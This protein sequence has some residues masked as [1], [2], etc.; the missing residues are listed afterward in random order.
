MS[1]AGSARTCHSER[2]E[3]SSFQALDN[4]GSLRKAG[5]S[6]TKILQSQRKADSSPSQAQGRN[7]KAWRSLARSN[8]MS[9]V[10]I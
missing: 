4:V 9:Q 8:D 3:E 6:Q 1:F 10:V 7:D 5:S 2:S